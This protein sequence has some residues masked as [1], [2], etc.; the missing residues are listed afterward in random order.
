MSSQAARSY[1]GKKE[2]KQQPWNH[3]DVD[4]TESESQNLD[5]SCCCGA[6]LSSTGHGQSQSS[7]SDIKSKASVKIMHVVVAGPCVVLR[8]SSGI[9][10]IV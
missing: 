6:A 3:L 10:P 7:M 8:D 5:L 4:G 1:R 9:V 2:R